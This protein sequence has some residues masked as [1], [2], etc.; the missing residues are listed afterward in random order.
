MDF[1]E[2]EGDDMNVGSDND[3]FVLSKPQDEFEGS[4]FF[5]SDDFIKKSKESIEDKFNNAS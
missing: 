2:D 1:D 5:V 4:I 3:E